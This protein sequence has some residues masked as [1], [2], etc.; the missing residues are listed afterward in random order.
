MMDD[1]EKKAAHIA[2][3]A[4][5]SIQTARWRIRNLPESAWY[6]TRYGRSQ[7]DTSD[8][9]RIAR[10]ADLAMKTIREVGGV[11]FVY[12]RGEHFAVK[13]APNSNWQSDL[14]GV[15]DRNTSR[16]WIVADLIEALRLERKQA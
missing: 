12:S 8:S 1:L 7:T 2:G 4:G 10:I 14:V 11:V 5:V 16:E 13:S 9:D 6:M 15:Y 3:I